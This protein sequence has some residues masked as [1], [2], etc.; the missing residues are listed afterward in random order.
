[1]I[2]AKRKEDL[3][4]KSWFRSDRHIQEGGSWYFYTREGT[5]QGPFDSKLEA[6]SCLEIYVNVTK[7]GLI[8]RE[9]ELASLA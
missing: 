2:I 6:A 4:V 8:E 1:M 3:V 9:F 5:L 7:L